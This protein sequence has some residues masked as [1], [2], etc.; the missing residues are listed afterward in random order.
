MG[1]DNNCL[2]YPIGTSG[3]GCR[4]KVLPGIKDRPPPAGK[5]RPL[6]PAFAFKQPGY[7]DEIHNRGTVPE[8]RVARLQGHCG[9]KSTQVLAP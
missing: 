1:V 2:D 7:S 6:G 4:L 5:E 8:S 9:Y 3:A